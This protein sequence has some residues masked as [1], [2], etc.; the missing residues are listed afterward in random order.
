MNH[1][2]RYIKPWRAGLA[3]LLLG[4]CQLLPGQPVP[5]PEAPASEAI[6]AQ[7]NST[8]CIATETEQQ[9]IENLTA[10]AEW[11]TATMRIAELEATVQ[12]LRYDLD[13]AEDTLLSTESGLQASLGRAD[14]VAR[15]AETQILFRHV[16]D[17]NPRRQDL[18]TVAKTKL[19]QA[20]R[21]ID[22]SNF[23]A[24]IFFIQRG[25]RILRSLQ[26]QTERLASAE[27]A[28]VVQVGTGTANLRAAPSTNAV[29]LLSLE[30][31]TPVYREESSGGW[32]L[33]R[34][35]EGQVG[36]IH[37]NLVQPIP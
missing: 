12:R 37:G 30:R 24:A 36:W 19:D 7:S 32:I 15:L 21:H 31:G 4:G 26:E 3:S 33:V 13:A 25:E 18:L 27:N 2:I 9:T 28:Y 29:I 14:T 17:L 22:E 1:T 5:V 16:A 34:T 11:R 23:G 10:R 6:T 8:E 20:D 35:S